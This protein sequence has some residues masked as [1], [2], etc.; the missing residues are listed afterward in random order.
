MTFHNVRFPT[1]LSFG[2]AGGPM[3][4]TEIITLSNGYEERNTPWQHARRKY[5]AGVAMQSVDDLEKLLHFFES[6]KGQLHG[7]RWK[8]WLDYKSCT[9]NK[10]PRDT[11]QEIG[12]GDGQKTEFQLVK[13]YASG[14][15]SYM[16]PIHKPVVQSVTLALD[17][18]AQTAGVDYTLDEHIGRISFTQPPAQDVKIT[19]GFEFDVPVRFDTDQIV[20]SLAHFKAGDV[21]SVPVIEIRI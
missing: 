6:R 2:A 8:D 7:F 1:N 16:R 19:A 5:D 18:S 11:D 4:R 14:G 17:G 3:R 15:Q 12:K 21:P 13:S 20:T 9:P 10:T